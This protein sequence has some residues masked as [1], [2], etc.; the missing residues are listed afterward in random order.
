MGFL[1]LRYSTIKLHDLKYHEFGYIPL[2]ATISPLYSQEEE[3]SRHSY[4]Y[5]NEKERCRD[6]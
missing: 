1:Q 3:M 2:D 5:I 6:G 4:I